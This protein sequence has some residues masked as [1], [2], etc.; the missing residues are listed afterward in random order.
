MSLY[1]DRAAASAA[2]ETSSMDAVNARDPAGRA[3]GR[4][5]TRAKGMA[6]LNM[7]I[8]C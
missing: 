3:N 5:A 2:V 8:E 7:V 4:T 1:P 6:R